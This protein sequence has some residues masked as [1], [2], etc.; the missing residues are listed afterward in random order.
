MEFNKIAAAVLLAGI[1]A[2]VSGIVSEKLYYGSKPHGKGEEVHRGYSI[3]IPEGGSESGIA[4]ADAAPVD[5]APYLADADLVAG[6]KLLRKCTACHTFE[7]GGA[8][9]VGP[10]QWALINRGIASHAGYAFSD[11][12]KALSAK[13]WTFQELS[14]FLEK[15]KKYAP[16]NK[17]A[18]IGLKK[19]EDRA[20]LLAYINQNFMPSP[21]P[22]PEVKP[23][24]PQSESVEGEVGAEK[25]E[26]AA[27]AK[28]E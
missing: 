19:P 1:I 16:G 7:K 25:G 12:L 22:L 23:E 21:A 11:A 13:N 5:I 27:D 15:P 3:D 18:F 10:S 4:V 17:M 8:E 14:E 26:S 6:E 28:P 20:N 2:M 24:A 9:G